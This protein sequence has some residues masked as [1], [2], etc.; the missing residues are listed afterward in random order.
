[1][2]DEGHFQK[3]AVGVFDDSQEVGLFLIKIRR[4]VRTAEEDDPVGPVE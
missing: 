1:M 3:M 4:D 2:E